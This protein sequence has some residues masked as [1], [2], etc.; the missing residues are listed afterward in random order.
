M[1]HTHIQSIARLLDV[2]RWINAKPAE[3]P[4]LLWSFAYFFFL[5]CSY[6]IIR[7]IRDEM[8]VSGGVENLQWLFLGTFLAMLAIVPVFGWVTSHFPRRK[9]LPYAYMF[10]IMNL[11]VFYVLLQSSMEQQYIAR[12]FFIWVSVFNLFVVSVFWSF[13]T[14]VYTEEQSKRLFGF[15][16]AGGSV[17]ALMGP[18]LTLSLVDR[19]GITHLLLLSALLLLC[20]IYCIWRLDQ[21]NQDMRATGGQSAVPTVSP[22]KHEKIA[23]GVW[24][25]IQLVAKSRYLLG[26]CLLIVLYT[27][28]STFLYFQ[29]AQIIRDSFIDSATR[30]AVFANMDFATNVLTLVFQVFLTG[31][32]VATVGIAWMLALVPLLLAAGFLIL[33]FAPI[34]WVIVVLQVLRRAGN[35]AI[36]RPAREMLFVVLG[37]EQKYKAKNFIDT[38]VYRSGDAFS[39]WVYAGFKTVGLP[40]AQI[41]FIA[42]PLSLLWAVV[43]FVLGKKHE[44]LVKQ[45]SEQL[46]VESP[47]DEAK[48]GAYSRDDR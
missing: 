11:L 8:G 35:F 33:S 22:L 36:M 43:A 23:G 24:A 40:L 48:N 4:A 39:A 47:E 25:G 32:I 45:Q 46:H 15:I 3:M 9:F 34:W 14:D 19:L 31:R 20:A 2:Q 17:G 21:W 29:Q 26:I 27:T 10:F 30:T 18:L 41:A 37:R 12:A 44:Q 7:P 1:A 16:A 13:M 28:L 6:Y 38:T 42:V 5:L